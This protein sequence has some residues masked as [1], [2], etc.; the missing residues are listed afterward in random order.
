MHSISFFIKQGRESILLQM[1]RLRP[2]LAGGVTGRLQSGSEPRALV[3]WLLLSLWVHLCPSTL[4]LLCDPTRGLLSASSHLLVRPHLCACWWLG[5]LWRYLLLVPG[6]LPFDHSSSYLALSWVLVLMLDLE[7]GLGRQR[8][9]FSSDFDLAA[10]VS[11]VGSSGRR[12]PLHLLVS[13]PITR[14]RPPGLDRL[15][16]TP[17]VQLANICWRKGSTTTYRDFWVLILAFFSWI[18]RPVTLRSSYYLTVTWN[19]ALH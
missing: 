15:P 19:H 7:F 11:T 18:M 1:R 8:P 9:P 6:K 13:I 14:L 2:R 10:P 17:G 16:L 12:V 4:V 5:V 3:L